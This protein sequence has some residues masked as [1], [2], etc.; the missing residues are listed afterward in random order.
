MTNPANAAFVPLSI[1][2]S[3]KSQRGDFRVL[4]AARPESARPLSTLEPAATNLSTGNGAHSTCE[5]SVTLQR[6]GDRIT[7][8]HIH[9]SCGQTIDLTCA[10]Q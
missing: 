10:Y 2:P 3:V 9:C 5:P 6:E 8:I 1:G 4:V 7:A